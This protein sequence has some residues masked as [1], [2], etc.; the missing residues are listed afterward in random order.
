[1]EDEWVYETNSGFVTP[2]H[3]LS[4]RGFESGRYIF[5]YTLDQLDRPTPR[6]AAY[7]SGIVQGEMGATLTCTLRHEDY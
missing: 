2:A 6:V 4:I 7:P 5:F 3:V 1:M